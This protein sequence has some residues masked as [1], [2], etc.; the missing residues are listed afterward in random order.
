MDEAAISA[1]FEI[2][3][4]LTAMFEASVPVKNAPPALPFRSKPAALWVFVFEMSADASVFSCD[5]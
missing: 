3:A 4:G 1:G 5:W 2:S